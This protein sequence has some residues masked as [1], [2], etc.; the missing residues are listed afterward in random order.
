M[1]SIED[2]PHERWVRNKGSTK[3]I[4]FLRTLISDDLSKSIISDSFHVFSTF[5]LFSTTICIISSHFEQPERIVGHFKNKSDSEQRAELH[6]KVLVRIWYL[7][8]GVR[9]LR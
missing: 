3:R 1:E 8:L 7:Y 5:L 9:L 6:Q 2:I 4:E